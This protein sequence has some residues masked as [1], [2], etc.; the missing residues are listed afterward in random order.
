[1]HACLNL[2]GLIDVLMEKS[3]ITINREGTLL[4]HD[5]L[6]EIVRRESPK[7]PSRRSRLW[8]CEDVLHILKNNTIS[9]LF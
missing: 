6:Q 5:F 7:E 2:I 3:L 4:M 8:L 1:M 9:C